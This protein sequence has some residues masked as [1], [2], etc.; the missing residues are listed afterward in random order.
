MSTKQEL[1][2]CSNCNETCYDDE[3]TGYHQRQGDD[4]YL[5]DECRETFEIENWPI[6]YI[7]GYE[8]ELTPEKQNELF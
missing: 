6:C 8:R 5:C 2:Y 1:N 4:I 3:I 7:F